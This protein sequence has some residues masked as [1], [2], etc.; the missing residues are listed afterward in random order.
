MALATNSEI[1]SKL[2]D[3][4]GLNADEVQHISFEFGTPITKLAE[5]KIIMLVSNEKLSMMARVFK[6][7]RLEEIEG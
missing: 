3:A 7:Y 1:G 5:I 2:C 6:R 4:L